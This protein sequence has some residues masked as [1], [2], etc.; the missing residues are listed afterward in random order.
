MKNLLISVA[1]HCFRSRLLYAGM[2]IAA[3]SG[4]IAGRQSAVT[5]EQTGAVYVM[6][7]DQSYL[8]ILP[9]LLLAAAVI[10][11]IGQEFADNAVRLKLIGGHS[12]TAICGAYFICAGMISL[13][14]AACYLIPF[15]LCLRGMLDS[16]PAES[17]VRVIVSLTLLF[18]LTGIFCAAVIVITGKQ[19]F[20][21]FLAVLLT[22]LCASLCTVTG[23]QLSH[24]DQYDTYTK[25]IEAPDGS[26]VRVRAVSRNNLY[27][28]SP[29]RE[30]LIIA[31]QMNPV[32]VLLQTLSLYDITWVTL[33]N[34]SV[35]D[36][37]TELASVEK[38]RSALAAQPAESPEHDETLR[39]LDKAAE[40]IKAE[41]AEWKWEGARTIRNLQDNV[42]GGPQVLAAW[43]IIL[44]SLGFFVFRRRDL[45]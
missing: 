16:V 9:L 40:Q 24:S 6:T 19:A 43:V 18:L 12:R 11:V 26:K 28:P 45:Q 20:S 17:R 32:T 3:L 22:V 31:H 1:Q 8:I 10:T 35:I 2:L 27:V 14:Y 21:V 5:E 38:E 25:Q 13:L 37:E 15:R 44:T 41:I 29:K 30:R 4:W 33:H 7:G 23:R 36:L 34:G 39:E 42:S